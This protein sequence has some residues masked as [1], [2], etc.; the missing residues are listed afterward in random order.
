[1]MSAPS[2]P[3]RRRFTLIELLVVIAIIAILASM[4]LPA[5]SQAREKACTISCASNEKQIGLSMFMYVNDNAERFPRVYTS[6]PS[7]SWYNDAQSYFSDTNVLLFPSQTRTGFG[8]GL[9]T[10]IANSTGRTLVEIPYPTKTCM[11]CEVYQAVDRSWPWDYG[12]DLRFEPDARH[13]D[14]LNMLFVDGHVDFFPSA[15]LKGTFHTPL[16]GSYWQ[17]NATSQ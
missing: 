4:L 11:F 17:P 15:K 8:Y 3:R 7:R 2:A 9:S 16:D 5:L 10:W 6:P 1:M 12:T 13:R 14:G